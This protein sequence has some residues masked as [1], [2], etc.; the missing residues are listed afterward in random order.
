[1]KKIKLMIIGTLFALMITGVAYASWT[2]SAN[3]SVNAASGELNIEITASRIDSKSNNIHFSS[4]DISI[5]A[6]KKSA[7]VNISN[8][9]P[10][11]AAEYTMTITNTGSLPV[12]LDRVT[13][14][15]MKVLDKNTGT[16]YGLDASLFAFI[17][18]RYSMI[19]YDINGI[20][21]GAVAPVNTENSSNWVEDYFASNTLP[22]IEPGETIELIT[23]VYF[24]ADADDTLENKVF[25]FSVAPVFAQVN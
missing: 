17:N 20:P 23:R 4:S 1:M 14:T 3:I 19:V 13:H 12:R 5:S 7:N 21:K 6:D 16:N 9:Y 24:D 11:A 18:A 22:S 10:G 2:D 15:T 25:V 8:G